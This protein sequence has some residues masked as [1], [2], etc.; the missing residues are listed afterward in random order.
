MIHCHFL[1]PDRFPAIIADFKLSLSKTSSSPSPSSSRPLSPSSPTN[2]SI[3]FRQSPSRML[4]SVRHGA[5]LGL[6]SFVTAFP[7]TVPRFFLLFFIWVKLC[8]IINH[9]PNLIIL[10]DCYL[11]SLFSLGDFSTTSSPSLPLSKRHFRLHLNQEMISK[12][13]NSFSEFQAHAPRQ[14]DGAQDRVHRGPAHRA[15]QPASLPKL[16]CIVRMR[17]LRRRT[18]TKMISSHGC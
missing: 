18:T 4:M 2:P 17:K 12:N 13:L 5:V 8:N 7:H 11:T 10:L 15:D 3:K 9:D 6:C 16:L 14:L 1:E